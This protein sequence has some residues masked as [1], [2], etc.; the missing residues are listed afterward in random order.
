M[1]KYAE[2]SIEMKKQWQVEA[3]CTLPVTVCNRSLSS[4]IAWFPQVT[5]LSRFGVRDHTKIGNLK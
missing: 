5:K 1:R 3:V 4:H 2:F